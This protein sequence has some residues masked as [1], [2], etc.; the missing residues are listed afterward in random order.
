[1]NL[2]RSARARYAR[3]IWKA[4]SHG[5]RPSALSQLLNRLVQHERWRKTEGMVVHPDGKPDILSPATVGC[6]LSLLGE[7]GA[8]SV[9]RDISGWRVGVDIYRRSPAP[10]AH[11]MPNSILGMALAEAL[12]T[13]W[14]QEE[15]RQGPR[16]H[17]L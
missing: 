8:V 1:M 15:R 12:L 13:A 10:Q 3:K 16:G 7:C 4:R 9:T 5:G 14:S 6:M 17:N 11:G 2:E